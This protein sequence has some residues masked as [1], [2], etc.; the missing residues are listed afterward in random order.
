[1]K[2]MKVTKGEPHPSSRR[3]AENA[4]KKLRR[5]LPF[6]WRERG[7]PSLSA[8]SRKARG[9]GEGSFGVETPF[10]YAFVQLHAVP[11]ISAALREEGL[12]RLGG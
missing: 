9:E 12:R 7:A 1:M 2:D 4:E 11:A 3:G 10:P 8:S 5:V 6:P